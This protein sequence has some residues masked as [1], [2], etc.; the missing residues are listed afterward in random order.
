MDIRL[1]VLS[2]RTQTAQRAKETQ[3]RL[4]HQ[5][6]LSAFTKA[7]IHQ[8]EQF[9][10]TKEEHQIFREKITYQLYDMIKIHS[11]Q[12]KSCKFVD[13]SQSDYNVLF[14]SYRPNAHNY[15]CHYNSFIFCGYY[16]FDRETIATMHRKKVFTK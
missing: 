15:L 7:N 5:D 12:L 2:N 9:V 10:Y 14:Q 3:L 4:M 11:N 13:E 6:E 1:V 8:Y 16:R